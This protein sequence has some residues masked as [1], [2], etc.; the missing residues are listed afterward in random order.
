M[1]ISLQ[2]LRAMSVEQR[3]SVFV[4]WLSQ[5]P[6]ST[7][8]QFTDS[9]DCAVCQ[10]AKSALGL[11]GVSSG[12]GKGHAFTAYGLNGECIAVVPPLD[13]Q[14]TWGW[15]NHPKV[16]L[17]NCSTLG[18]LYD[19]LLHLVTPPLLPPVELSEA[20]LEA[21]ELRPLVSFQH[22]KA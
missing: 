15:Q 5:Q 1:K 3:V 8:Y 22:T 16:A 14:T 13:D 17:N 11:K 6:R 12:S 7:P 21:L 9:A 10:F 18:E 19:R 4:G 2:E 20:A